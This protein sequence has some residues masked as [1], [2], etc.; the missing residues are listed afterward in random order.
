VTAGLVLIL[1]S[2]GGS[3]R[4]AVQ[5]I[6]LAVPDPDDWLAAERP[7]QREGTLSVRVGLKDAA[8]SAELG[9]ESQPLSLVWDRRA[10][11]DEVRERSPLERQLTADGRPVLFTTN[12]SP[13]VPWP[14]YLALHADGY[15]RA[16]LL[17]VDRTLDQLTMT[18]WKQNRPAAVVITGLKATAGRPGPQARTA[19][20][21]F[22]PSQPWLPLP[23]APLEEG[24]VL[25]PAG[26]PLLVRVEEDAP[27]VRLEADLGAEIASRYF[28][29]G[30]QI[31]LEA[32][33][34][35]H[36]LATGRRVRV[37]WRGVGEA[38]FELA[39]EVGDWQ[40]LPLGTW[41]V[42]EDQRIDVVARVVGE[43]GGPP[44]LPA[45]EDRAVVILDRTPPAVRQLTAEA[46][47]TPLGTT[48][49]LKPRVRFRCR[50]DDGLGSG[51]DKVEFAAGFDALLKNSRL[52]PEER[53]G[54]P[55]SVP[56]SAARDGWFEATLELPGEI[57]PQPLLV[58]ARALDRVG[59][60]SR[61]ERA[62]LVVR[63][64]GGDRAT[65][66]QGSEK[67]GVPSKKSIDNP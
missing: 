45:S 6:E 16:L 48:A 8:L 65:F 9:L 44:P 23:A 57:P 58:E 37:L 56:A 11:P 14:L 26:T 22:W 41:E 7:E 27:Q 36:D 67:K 34:Q 5:W 47:P 10:L 54:E 60:A 55:L 31:R 21:A 20:C 43:G 64:P 19:A 66:G 61:T 38:G 12:L 32:A 59:F 3:R 63:K 13:A 40:R 53:I 30:C 28:A 17:R 25:R 46:V 51:I 42:P 33:G 29:A 24:V 2:Q 4:P 1:T 52:D 18:N 35:I 15:P 49:P 39:S 62:S 50:A